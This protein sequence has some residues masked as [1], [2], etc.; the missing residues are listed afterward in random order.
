MTKKL[1]AYKILV[2][3]GGGVKLGRKLFRT[4]G[5]RRIILR[6]NLRKW[7]FEIR[8]WNQFRMPPT[9]ELRIA[10]YYRRITLLLWR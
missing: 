7:V 2:L 10:F 5:K 3:G 1:T 4:L 9:S 8:I 6:W